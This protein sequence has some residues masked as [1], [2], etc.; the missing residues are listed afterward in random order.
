MVTRKKNPEDY[1]KNTINSMIG[2]FPEMG[3][4]PPDLESINDGRAH[5]ETLGNFS[6]VTLDVYFFL[7]SK[8]NKYF[9]MQTQVMTDFG[10]ISLG[11][12]VEMVRK[13]KRKTKD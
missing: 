6:K 12:A 4:E 8:E 3:I 2:P 7:N 11:K 1:W 10:E 5:L 13:K 9:T